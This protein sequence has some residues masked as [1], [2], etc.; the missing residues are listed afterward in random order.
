MG[1]SD[2]LSRCADHG[3]SSDDNRDI[4][5]LTPKFFAVR[6]LEGVQVEGQERELLKLIRKETRDGEL[7]DAVS[8]AA[9]ALKSSSAKSRRS[10]EWSE[11]DGVLYFRGK[12]YVP[13]S[14]DIRRKIV[15]LHH[16]SM[17]AGH[18][19]R[20]KTLELVSWNY[21]W[22]Q[23][24]RYIGHYTSTCDLCL[25]TKVQRQL[26]T[27]HLEPL[28]TPD[29]WWHTVSVDFV[30]ELPES[31]GY[32]AVMVVVDSLTKRVHFN[33]VNTTITAVG[34]ARQFRDNVWKHHGLLT[35]IV[36]DRSPQFTAKFTTEVY[37]LLGIEGAKTTAYHPQVDRQTEQVNQE[38]EQYLRLFCSERQND[39]ADLLPMAEFHYNNHIHSST[40]QTP[41]MLN[42]G[43]HPRMGFEPQPPSRLESA[44]EF[45]DRMKCAM[46]E[47][48]A[49]LAK[50][51]DDMARY[52]NQRRLPTPTYQPGDKVYL[53]ASDISTTRPSWKLSHRRL[54]PFPVER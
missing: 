2:A 7:E 43:Q 15:A 26:L 35:R 1:K 29:T 31:D 16:D 38:L 27:G 4:T 52:Y 41:F 42:C 21:W 19:G 20:W 44:N 3:S 36:S 17:I 50:A 5:L 30:V 46:E 54:G 8:K 40:Q 34:S 13:P 49:A 33:P 22:P 24:S 23:M 28:P 51:K 45:T 12:I 9:K 18:P 25:R 39:W 37:W 48:K 32:D 14:S 47:A 6:A 11:V 53:D 10:S